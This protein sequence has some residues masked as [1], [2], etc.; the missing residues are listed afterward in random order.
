MGVVLPVVVSPR[1]RY[2]L[3]EASTDDRRQRGD[4]RLSPWASI[5]RR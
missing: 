2:R 1:R 4:E 3:P 5:T